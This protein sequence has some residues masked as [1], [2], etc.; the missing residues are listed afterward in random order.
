[1]SELLSGNQN[2][3]KSFAQKLKASLGHSAFLL[4]LSVG[5]LIASGSLLY[6]Q[7]QAQQH[8]LDSAHPI[9]SQL[10]VT[11]DYIENEYV[12]EIDSERLNKV[13][14][15]AVMQELDHHSTYLDQSAYRNLVTDTDGSYA[16][17]G[18]EIEH[19]KQRIFVLNTVPGSPAAKIGLKAGD[20]ILKINGLDA[21]SN[22]FTELQSKMQGALGTSL[23]LT[24]QRSDTPEQFR[25]SALNN[26]PFSATEIIDVNL[27]R[28]IIPIDSVKSAHLA[29]G[30]AYLQLSHFTDQSAKDLT[31]AIKNWQA[32][33]DP[34]TGII[35]DLRDNPGGLVTAAVDIADLFLEKGVIV[36]AEGRAQDA[37][38]RHKATRG[39][40]IENLPIVILINQATASS[41]EIVAAALKD[42]KRA[43]IVGYQSFGKG[44]VQSIIPMEQGDA[45]K[46]TTSH[47]FTPSGQ[48]LQ[49]RGVIPDISIEE[50]GVA[51]KV[52]ELHA[53]NI[54]SAMQNEEKLLY[55]LMTTLAIKDPTL[56][57]AW[58][59][60]DNLHKPVHSKIAMDQSEEK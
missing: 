23:K 49:G 21:S 48:S 38:F 29:N 60:L 46:L 59:H 57:R 50:A 45:L 44:S 43:V 16:G 28:S 13:A 20:E 15:K 9:K 31:K 52:S 58:Q 1:M 41:A 56:L 55:S 19:I 37:N 35:L 2:H 30:I 25:N 34:M 3:K 5:I 17:I 54:P 8:H 27:V 18:I 40:I 12:N 39:D 6:T 14:I 24:L 11:L 51:I 22:T 47:Y 7:Q 4:G 33:T 32:K 42:S 36:T 53:L 26:T 10:E